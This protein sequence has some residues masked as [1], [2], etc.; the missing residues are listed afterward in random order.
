MKKGIKILMVILLI[1]LVIAVCLFLFKDKKEEMN[2]TYALDIAKRKYE[3]LLNYAEANNIEISGNEDNLE[4]YIFNEKNYFQIDNFEDTIQSD[5]CDEFIED[6][7][8]IANIINVNG[9]YYISAE[10]ISREKDITYKS[11]Q[12]IVES[13]NNDT[14][15][16]EAKSNYSGYAGNN[17]HSIS[18]KFSIKNVDGIWKVNEF[19]LPY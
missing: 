2:E 3:M 4:G 18:R 16:C 8:K 5:I 14:I 9:K 10:S 6:F 15:I 19:E 7:C 17:N 1:I 11:T 13:A 12:L